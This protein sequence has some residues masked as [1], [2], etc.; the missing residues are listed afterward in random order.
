MK[1]LATLL[2]VAVMTMFM[3]PASVYSAPPGPPGDSPNG[4]F[5]NG[6]FY[7]HGALYK[8]YIY[9]NRI[10]LRYD[11]YRCADGSWVYVGSSDDIN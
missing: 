8:E 5:K 7:P 9:F 3:L 10:L 1:A 6:N 11:V 4:C 2:I